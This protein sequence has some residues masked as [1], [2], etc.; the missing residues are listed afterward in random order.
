MVFMTQGKRFGLSAVQKCDMWR[1][2]KAGQS[3]HEIG[4]A[5]GKPHTSI[6]CLVAPHGGFVPAVRQRSLLALTLLEREEI[7]RGIASGSS[8]REIA[9]CLDRTVSTVCR[10]VARHGGRSVY[11]ANPADDE[12][13]ESALRPKRCLLSLHV[14]LRELVASKLILD[15]S[16]EQI[17]GWL[18]TQYPDD[19]SLRVSHETIYR[20]LFIQA[21]GVLK[22]ELL[23]HLRSKRRI[24][25]SQHSHIF[26]DSRGQIV[27]AISIRERPSEIQDRAIPGHWEG[28]LLGG[29]NNSHVVT[30]VERHSR[31]TTLVKVPSKDTAVVVAALTRH[32]RKLPASLRRSL[33][34]DRGLE[35]AKH[36]TFTVATNV[37]VYFCDPQSPWQRGSNENT[38]GLLRQYL[39]KR[40][41]LS[42]YSQSD[43]DKIALRLNQRP[44][45][46]LAFQTPASKLP[47]SVALTH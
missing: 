27:D 3:L 39:P 2:W 23:G 6:R 32:V 5:F 35:M 42:G 15:W 4:R 10:E 18:K 28:D 38:N 33:T 34:W 17:S 37:K 8:I 29:S 13:W 22:K 26:K 25:R 36:K 31:F 12:A 46:T 20:S 40:T 21:R 9:K 16:P 30:L 44:R 41:D 43:L 11:R 19:K 45:K 47:A 14:K 24:R 1:R 7:S